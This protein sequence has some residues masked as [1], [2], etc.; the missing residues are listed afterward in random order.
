MRSLTSVYKPAVSVLM[1]GPEDA[2]DRG[3]YAD[4]LRPGSTALEQLIVTR[5]NHVRQ[6]LTATGAKFL[7]LPVQCDGT[8]DVSAARID[9]LDQ[10]LEEWAS[11]SPGHVAYLADMRQP[12]TSKRLDPKATWEQIAAAVKTG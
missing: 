7:L 12:C 8:T 5:L 1:I 3:V 10:L 9:W 11:T 2:R 4:V 6:A